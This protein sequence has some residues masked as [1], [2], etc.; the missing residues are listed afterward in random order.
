MTIVTSM[1]QKYQSPPNRR[2]TTIFF[3][4]IFLIGMKLRFGVRLENSHF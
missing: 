1:I 2:C 4:M 3:E